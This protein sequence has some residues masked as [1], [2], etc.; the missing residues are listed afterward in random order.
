MHLTVLAVPG[1]PNASL[2]CSGYGVVLLLS[3]RTLRD[4]S[5]AAADQGAGWPARVCL[6][7]LPAR[8]RL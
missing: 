5:R 4:S 8:G 1:C 6:A 2:P 3:Y 7:P